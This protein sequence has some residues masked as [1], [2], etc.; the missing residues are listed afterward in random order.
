M[1]KE[2]ACN[3]GDLGL[4]PGLRRSPGEENGN[5]LQYSCLENPMNRGAWWVTVH[6]VSKSQTRLSN[7]LYFYAYIQGFPGGSVVMNPPTNAEVASLIPGSGRSPREG[8]GNP[9]QYSSWEIPRTGETGRLQSTGSQNSQTQQINNNAYIQ[10][11]P[12][13]ITYEWADAF[14]LYINA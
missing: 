13:F 6:G 10:I 5:P 9:L 12:F 1:E 8:N 7:Q 14:S 2:F 4:I 11:I 3:V